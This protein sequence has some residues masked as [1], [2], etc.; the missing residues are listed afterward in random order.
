MRLILA[1]GVIRSSVVCCVAAPVGR[2]GGAGLPIASFPV[3]AH[4][5]LQ[6]YAL[7]FITEPV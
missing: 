4:A 3:A 5:P 7:P 2:G 1:R 6:A